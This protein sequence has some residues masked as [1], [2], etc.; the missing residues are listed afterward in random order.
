MKVEWE[1]DRNIWYFP[2]NFRYD[3]EVIYH[4]YKIKI[5]STQLN[6]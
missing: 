3:K 6:L 2:K 5:L 4:T 1:E